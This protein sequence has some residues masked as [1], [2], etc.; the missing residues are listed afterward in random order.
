MSRVYKILSQSEWDQAVAAGEFAGAEI[1][2]RDGYIHLSTAEQA[3]ATARLHFH[4]KAGLLVLELES[5]TLGNAL[6]WEPSRGGQLFPHYYGVLPVSA[7]L[8]VRPAPLGD[9]GIPDLGP[10]AEP[11]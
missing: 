4:G 6:R 2:I 8:S 11:T 10:L 9:D 5:G 3:P 7:I 1:D